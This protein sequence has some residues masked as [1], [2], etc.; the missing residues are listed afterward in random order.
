[1]GGEKDPKTGKSLKG[2]EEFWNSEG[3]PMLNWKGKGYATILDVLLASNLDQV[4]FNAFPKHIQK[5]QNR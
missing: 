3:D 1:M 2:L 5:A 4:F